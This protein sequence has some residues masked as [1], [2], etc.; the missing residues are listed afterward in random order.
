MEKKI[1]KNIKTK[2]LYSIGE[3]AKY[4]QERTNNPKFSTQLLLWYIGRNTDEFDWA[5]LGQGKK[6]NNYIIFNQKA[7]NWRYNG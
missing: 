4:I 2:D 7:K 6:R 5:K 3:Y 1:L